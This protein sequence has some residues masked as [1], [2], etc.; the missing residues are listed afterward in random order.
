VH[1]P[2]FNGLRQGIAMA[3]F[4]Y[5][6]P[7]LINKKIFKYILICLFASTFHISVLIMIP[8]Y[9]VVN[10]QVKTIYKVIAVVIGTSIASAPL[11]QYMAKDNA[12][13]EGYTVGDN[14]GGLFTLGLYITLALFILGM[15]IKLKIKDVLFNKL[16]TLYFSGVALLVPVALLGAGAS[17][18]QRILSYFSWTLIIILPMIINKFN[19]NLI[20]FLF[21]VVC[22]VYYYL[23]TT[24]FSNLTPYMINPFFEML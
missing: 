18:P 19:S 5:A 24:R 17:G 2:S 9:F 11:I 6:I 20:K 10:L 8:F 23:S 16:L 15:N 21:I 7:A 3:I 4:L 13:Y 1:I 14:F 22:I 12:R